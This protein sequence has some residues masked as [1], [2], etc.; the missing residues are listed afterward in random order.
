MDRAPLTI[1]FAL[2]VLFSCLTWLASWPPLL[3]RHIASLPNCD[4][5][6]RR[7]PRA[8]SNGRAGRPGLRV[9][10]QLWDQVAKA[11]DWDRVFQIQSAYLRVSLERATELTR[12]YIEVSQAV[13]TATA[14]AAQRQ[15]KEAA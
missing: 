6:R 13:L 7:G 10:P 2:A 1:R 14:S 8:G 15:A 9:R 4:A 11:V 3:L 5:S 12:R